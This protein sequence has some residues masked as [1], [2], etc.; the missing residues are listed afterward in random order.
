MGGAIMT[1][2]LVT[3]TNRRSQ[4]LSLDGTPFVA[5]PVM[6]SYTAAAMRTAYLATL[7]R[8]FSAVNRETTRWSGPRTSNIRMTQAMATT[9]SLGA[10]GVI[11]FTAAPVVLLKFLFQSQAVRK[12]TSWTE[13]P[14]KTLCT[15]T[16]APIIWQAA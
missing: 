9:C 2:S 15:V 14:A 1:R 5:D 10:K 7:A 16:A 8:I 11:G 4:I 3:M 13:V 12:R 6:T